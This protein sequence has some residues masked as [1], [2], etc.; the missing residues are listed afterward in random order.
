MCI[1]KNAQLVEMRDCLL[2]KLLSG[3]VRVSEATHSSAV[4]A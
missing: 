2:P 4:V 3:D 1:K